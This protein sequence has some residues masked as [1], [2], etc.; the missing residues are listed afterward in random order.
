MNIWA[1]NIW[2][3][4]LI[5]AIFGEF[6]ISY[7][8]G[9][10][11]PGYNHKQDVM[12]LL[13]NPNSPVSFLYNIWLVILGIIICSSSIKI[14]FEYFVVS[15]SLAITTLTIMMVFGIGAGILSG[16]FSVSETKDIENLASKIHGIGAGVG[17]ILFTFVPLLIGLLSLKIDNYMIGI[18]SIILFFISIIF[19]ILFILSEK[20]RFQYSVIGLSG[21]W[22]RLLLGT[23]YLPLLLVAFKQISVAKSS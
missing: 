5:I 9:F 7:F 17:F 14:Y 22:Q 21:L 15:K 3:I 1:S 11:Y 13:G 8:L 4:L 19:F 12:S 2:W 20:E 10:F 18:V 23:M 16:I 6:V